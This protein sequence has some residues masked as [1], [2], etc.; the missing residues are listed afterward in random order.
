MCNIKDLV[1]E[2][3]E[4]MKMPHEGLYCYMFRDKT[5]FIAERDH[6]MQHTFLPKPTRAQ[7]QSSL[8]LSCLD[9]LCCECIDTMSD[10]EENIR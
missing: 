8:M 3:C 2:T 1:C 4:I 6:C 10:I 7:A 9:I 5:R